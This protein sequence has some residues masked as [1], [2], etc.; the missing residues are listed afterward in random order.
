MVSPMLS[1]HRL[2]RP[3]VAPT[4]SKRFPREAHEQSD[5]CN[6]SLASHAP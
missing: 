2:L 1:C 6:A 4:G 5:R 3:L